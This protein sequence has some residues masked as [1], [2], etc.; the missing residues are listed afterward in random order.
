[1]S[2]SPPVFGDYSLD[3]PLSTLDTEKKM[4]ACIVFFCSFIAAATSE[5]LQSSKPSHYTSCDSL[6]TCTEKDGVLYVNYLRGNQLQSLPY[7]GFLEHIG[8]I[9]ELLLDDN[10]WVCE[11]EIIPL[12]IW[13]ENMR[14]L[15]AMSEVVCVTPP[16][17]KGSILSKV[18]KEVLCPASR[19]LEDPS[20]PSVTEVSPTP[21]VIRNPKLMDDGKIPTPGHP[22]AKFCIERCSCH[23]HLI[24]GFLVHCQDRVFCAAGIIVLVLHRQRESKKKEMEDQPR[25]SS[26]IHLQ[27]SMFGQKTTHHLSSSPRINMY[28]EPTRSPIIQVC[29]NASYCTHHK[30]HELEEQDASEGKGICMGLPEK[31]NDSPLTGRP[32]VKYRAVVEYPSDFVTLGDTNCL[33]RNIIER[34]K[35]VQQLGITEYLRKNISQL[36]PVLDVPSQGRHD[37]L[38]LMETIMYTRPRKVVVEQSK[39]EYFELKANLQAEPDYLEVLE[40]QTTFN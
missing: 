2:R 26:P 39:N 12:K 14:T 20:K 40:H 8:R 38:K 29:R 36:Q 5:G 22:P 30:E 34:E 28:E 19:D 9:M 13:M 11:C 16:H 27:Y 3:S 18:K 24:A 6:C 32:S 31:E 1:M 15:S 17:L 23:N 4:L 33:Y 7:V 35:E 25:E 37:E 10:A 21:R